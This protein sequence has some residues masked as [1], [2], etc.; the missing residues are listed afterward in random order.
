MTVELEFPAPGPWIQQNQAW[1]IAAIDEIR[2]ELRGPFQNEHDNLGGRVA[3]DRRAA[4]IA[5]HHIDPPAFERL[6]ATF[7]LGP[8]EARI[9]LLCAAAELSADIGALCAAARGGGGQPFPTFGLALASFAQPA[10]SALAPSAPLMRW[11]LVRRADGP[12]LTAA[13][14]SVDAR[15]LDAILGLDAAD[16]RLAGLVAPST[17][18]AT[19]Y[20]TETAL[21]QTI[22]RRLRT[23]ADNG[24]SPIVQLSGGRVHARLHVARASAAM[25]DVELM[26]IN[27]AALMRDDPRTL[28]DLVQREFLLSGRIALIDMAD[29][30]PADA[31]PFEQLLATV[32]VPI[33]IGVSA[34][35]TLSQ[36]ATTALAMPV[37]TIGERRE[38]WHRVLECPRG[39]NAAVDDA[40]GR[41]AVQFALGASDIHAAAAQAAADGAPDFAG[42]WAACRGLAQPQLDDLAQR[43]VPRA[44][45]DDLVLPSRATAL[46]HGI[47]DQ[48]RGR[49]QVYDDWGFADR[50]GGL[51]IAALFAGSSGMGK[52]MAAE[53]IAR[54]LDLDLYRVDISSIV[55]KYIGE[56]EKHLRTLFDAAEDGGAILLFDEADAL[57][58]RRSEVKDSHDRYS[59]IEVS[60]LLQRIESYSGLAILTTNM[61]SALDEAFVRR[62]RFIVD[63]GF[64]AEAER[65]RLWAGAFP[66][67]TPVKAL[68]YRRLAQLTIGGGAVRNV[69]LTAAFVAN[70]RAEP[71]TMG[72]VA[73]AVRREYAKQGRVPTRGELE[74]WAD[75]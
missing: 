21:A 10:W 28:L 3:I 41:L 4:A 31:A 48:V 44:T 65:A 66:P 29:L 33:L 12:S 25:L 57:F 72:A 73:E 46:L 49:A 71:I 26:S 43:I 55:S 2:D 20:D 27:A 75:A 70:A 63:F 67:D 56:T 52:T 74:G 5:W 60:Y 22:A 64:P 13:R 23:P 15:I 24:L 6:A 53:V 1:L 14:L 32:R 50:T 40:I 30:S 11:H 62:L 45:W 19:L 47:V 9:L 35:R 8:F 69:V 38:A 34:P 54:D 17:R 59:N 36:R 68:D 42:L 39:A 16:H 58:G 18:M 7:G 61:K 37:P 51:G